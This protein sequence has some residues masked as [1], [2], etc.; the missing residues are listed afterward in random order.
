MSEVVGAIVS[1][2]ILVPEE[3]MLLM[4]WVGAIAILLA[5]LIEVLFGHKKITEPV[6]SM[7]TW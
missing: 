5:G 2:A 7:Y 6:H 1:A 4:Q 3:T